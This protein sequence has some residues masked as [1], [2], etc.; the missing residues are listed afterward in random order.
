MAVSLIV[1]DSDGSSSL[2]A[3]NNLQYFTGIFTI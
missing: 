3:A 1:I 2:R